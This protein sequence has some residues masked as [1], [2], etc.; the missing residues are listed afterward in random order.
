MKHNK[1][2]LALIGMMGTGKTTVGQAIAAQT[3]LPWKDTDQ[4]LI[5]KWGCSIADFFHHYGEERFRDEEEK[6]LQACLAEPTQ[7]L[8]TGGGIV[9]REQ[10]RKRLSERA[11]VVHLDAEPKEIIRRLAKAKE[12]RPLL[13]GD[14]H[15]RVYEIYEAR[16]ELYQF[17]DVRVD[18]TGK[19]ADDLATAIVR[20]WRNHV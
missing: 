10:N 18:T 16:Q 1:Q 12:E 20:A 14:L 9:L 7:L 13:Q 2:H 3:S 19:S 5:A 11:F 15:R 4:A 8:T 6:M 17:A